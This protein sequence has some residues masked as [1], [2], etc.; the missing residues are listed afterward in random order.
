MTSHLAASHPCSRDNGGC[1]H[2]CIAKGDGTPRC[3]CPMHL[4]LLQN[5]LSC[6]GKC[7]LC[8]HTV[9]VFSLY[10][11]LAHTI[12][13][14]PTIPSEPPTCSSE[15]FTCATGEIDCIPMAWRCDGIAE[16]ADH[17]D[18]MNCPICSG[19]QFQCDKGQCVD[20][21]LRC[22]G[23]PD[24]ADGSDEQDCEST[25]GCYAEL[26][27]FVYLKN[28]LCC[29]NGGNYCCSYS[30]AFCLFPNSHLY[31]QSV[32][33]WQQPVYPEKTTMRLIPRLRR[34]L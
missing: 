34:R 9:P 30:D 15:Q 20:A 12:T 10:F 14:L 29:A 11:F 33:L 16:C 3:S 31:A 6:G 18:E 4:V 13:C 22:N 1:S 5:L 24:C 21:Q 27:Y 25:S 19:L 8:T 23:E 28:R 26:K 32:P 2:I 17:S 7:Y